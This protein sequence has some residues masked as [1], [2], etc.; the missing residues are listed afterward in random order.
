[1][2]GVQCALQWIVSLDVI[3]LAGEEGCAF[4]VFGRVLGKK[5]HLTE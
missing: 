2:R 3:R 5:Q 1:M 4:L